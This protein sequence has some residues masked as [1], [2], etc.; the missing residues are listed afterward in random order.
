MKR[1]LA[2]ILVLIAVCALSC[3][4]F[5]QSDSCNSTN[6]WKHVYHPDRFIIEQKCLTVSGT[7]FSILREADGD[8]HIRLTLD[9]GQESLLNQKNIDAQHGCLVIEIIYVHAVTQADAIDDSKGY[10]NDVYV[11]KVGQHVLVTGPYVLDQQHGWKEIHPVTDV[12][13]IH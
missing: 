5:A 6:K 10:Q 9:K 7:I 13:L 11:P 2:F 8:V 1:I 12:T 4:A 3:G